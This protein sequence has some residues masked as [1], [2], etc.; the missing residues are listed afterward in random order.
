M[1]AV[2]TKPVFFQWQKSHGYPVF[3]RV[4]KTLLE[5][6][7]QKLITDLGFQEVPV[8]EHRKIQLDRMGTKVLTLSRASLRVCQ[9]VNLGD[10]LER[11]GAESLSH[12]AN[13]QVYLYRRLGLMVFSPLTNLWELGLASQLETT[14]ELT[15]LRVMLNRYLGWAL[16]PLGVIGFWGVATNEGLVAMKQ[17]QSFGEVVMVDVEKRLLHSSAGTQPMAPGFT[18]LRADKGAPAG[19]AM[20]REELVSFLSTANV[21]FTH[22]NLPYTLRK[23][24]LA[25]G[26]L[27]RGEWSGHASALGGLSNA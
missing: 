19:K 11:Y 15:G 2:S 4:E 16:A 24:A 23:T 20:A 1:S 5:G 13:A 25:L 10:S 6:R 8:S 27:A 18:I 12:H 22:G 9:Q 3:L 14:E 7:L 17:S 21:Y 26:S